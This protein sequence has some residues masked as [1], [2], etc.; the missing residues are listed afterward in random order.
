MTN[1]ALFEK[2]YFKYDGFFHKFI[3][4]DTTVTVVNL[5]PKETPVSSLIGSCP[6][7]DI[8][9][10]I[11]ESTGGTYYEYDELISACEA[12]SYD[13]VVCTPFQRATIFRKSSFTN[14]INE[15]KE[16]FMKLPLNRDAVE[17]IT[18]SLCEEHI[19]TAKTCLLCGNLLRY[20]LEIPYMNTIVSTRSRE[21]FTLSKAEKVNV[22][23]L[24]TRMFFSWNK[25]IKILYTAISLIPQS[26]VSITAREKAKGTKTKK[27][28][29]V[30][31]S[32]LAPYYTIRQMHMY[33]QEVMN[34]QN[35]TTL[36]NILTIALCFK[37]GNEVTQAKFHNSDRMVTN[38]LGFLKSIEETDKRINN[39][40]FLPCQE[41]SEDFLRHKILML[42]A[43]QLRFN[44]R[45]EK[46]Y[47]TLKS[48]N[49][50]H[51]LREVDS[52]II[53][54]G[55]TQLLRVIKDL[56][57]AKTEETEG[58]ISI[59]SQREFPKTPFTMTFACDIR[60]HEH[61]IQAKS[62]SVNI[63][64]L[65]H[66]EIHWETPLLFKITLSYFS[67]YSWVSHNFT[68]ALS[69]F[70]RLSDVNTHT[71]TYTANI[72][73]N[74]LLFTQKD[75]VLCQIK[76]KT[77]VRHLISYQTREENVQ[78]K[79]LCRVTSPLPLKRVLF[80]VMPHRRY[81]WEL[82]KTDNGNIEL[83]NWMI[84]LISRCRMHEGLT[85]LSETSHSFYHSVPLY[86]ING[87]N[88]LTRQKETSEEEEKGLLVD[89]RNFTNHWTSLQYTSY[90]TESGVVTE[91][92]MEPYN[93]EI[94]FSKGKKM[95]KHDLFNALAEWF[96]VNDMY[97]IKSAR[98]FNK[99]KEI[100]LAMSE[101]ERE[102]L[103]NEFMTHN[104]ISSPGKDNFHSITKF[105]NTNDYTRTHTYQNKHEHIFIGA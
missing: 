1:G 53:L 77:L 85:P 46:L 58:Y 36:H 8:L 89:T 42:K 74:L 5:G 50:F 45:Q 72:P 97:I 88:M 69:N 41:L 47:F 24:Q 56:E 34:I 16:V 28:M 32:V 18:T 78:D 11:A 91:L 26:R 59:I 39:L 17:A 23:H 35:I 20:E 21:G 44:T 55:A 60:N 10:S 19:S 61:R 64:P 15:S 75:S 103:R 80:Y 38:L 105:V 79:T 6:D 96:L 13:I 92:W 7:L 37:Q 84:S 99:I 94:G 31:I 43:K 98:T 40:A 86:P 73:T 81:V 22:S 62:C 57:P 76:S 54:Q 102:N 90:L 83:L 49:P 82:N 93:G 63:Q 104:E 25:N 95:F 65:L 67:V 66:M 51:N 9:A 68:E 14:P 87:Y 100:F 12:K 30:E 2:T 33:L 29:R 3:R 4:N 71:H 27:A 52:R 48:Q 101:Q 70:I